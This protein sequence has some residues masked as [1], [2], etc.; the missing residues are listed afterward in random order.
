MCTSC[1]S[2]AVD[3]R[4]NHLGIDL[5]LEHEQLSQNGLHSGRENRKLSATMEPDLDGRRVRGMQGAPQ[6]LSETNRDNSSDYD[7]LGP[8]P[9]DQSVLRRDS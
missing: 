7:I 5:E 3:A 4:K 2:V 9:L 1:T 6:S 8:D